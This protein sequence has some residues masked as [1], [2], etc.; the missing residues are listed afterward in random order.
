M[1][2]EISAELHG[3]TAKTANIGAAI[4]EMPF[5]LFML[6]LEDKIQKPNDHFFGFSIGVNVM[7]QQSGDGGFIKGIDILA[8]S[9]W[10]RSSKLRDAG[11]EDRPCAEQD[12]PKFSL[13]EEGQSPQKAP[14][15]RPVSTRKTDRLHDL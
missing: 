4:R 10:K 12:H 3:W 15:R 14:K 8:I 13:Q 11:R 9:L 2:V 7:D 6:M 5:T 1:P